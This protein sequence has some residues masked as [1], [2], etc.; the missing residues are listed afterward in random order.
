MIETPTLTGG[1]FSSGGNCPDTKEM[2]KKIS[3]DHKAIKD[4]TALSESNAREKLLHFLLFQIKF[5]VIAT[6]NS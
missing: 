6:K 5:Y 1:E 2:V 4:L 3:S